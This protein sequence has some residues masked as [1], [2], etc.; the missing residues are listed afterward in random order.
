MT[1]N[2]SDV[3]VSV[4]NDFWSAPLVA[5]LHNA[6]FK[7]THHTT[8][9]QKAPCDRFIR[10]IPAA[11]L[12]HLTYRN[13]IP[14]NA[15]HA[16]SRKIIDYNGYT[17]AESSRSFWGWSGCALKGLKRARAAGKPAILERGSSHCIWQKIQVAREYKRLGL[18][19]NEI[20]TKLELEY[21]V[22]EYA[23]ADFICV[24]SRFVFD[25][26]LEMGVPQ[27]KIF[28]NPYGVDHEFWSKCDTSNR[29]SEPFTFL[30]VAALMPRKGIG[31]L[32]EAWRKVDFRNA[33]LVLIGGISSSIKPLLKNL[34]RNVY[35]RSHLDHHAIRKEMSRS[36]VYVLPSLEEGMARSVLEAAAAGLPALI[37]EE[38]GATDLLHDGTSAHVIP[39]GNVDAL[40]QALSHFYKHPELAVEMGANARVA[41]K[42]YTWENYGERAAKFLKKIMKN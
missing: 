3:T 40:A 17:L 9:G 32:L 11:A 38:T 15:A 36:H 33:R 28:L 18:R 19:M 20:S 24:P 12:N 31:V 41:V 34:P 14:Q 35:I 23:A 29:F 6:G 4:W 22:K 30:W 25:T 27:N 39:S 13:L 26:F 7:V 21:D 8:G 10:N 1:N 42:S 5:G 37:T 16:W 2:H